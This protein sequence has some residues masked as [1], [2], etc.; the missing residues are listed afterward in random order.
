MSGRADH[1]MAS[2]HHQQGLWSGRWAQRKVPGHGRG[3][4]V[5]APHVSERRHELIQPSLL[6]QKF[7]LL[8]KVLSRDTREHMMLQ[9]K[10]EDETLGV[11]SLWG[12][13]KQV[14]LRGPHPGTGSGFGDGAWG[15]QAAN[16]GL[17][18]GCVLFSL[19]S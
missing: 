10:P 2:G 1:L 3:A 13:L 5:P 18:G 8:I 9:S 11:Q 7:S 14:P 15:P 4:W 12:P 19:N 6:L 17:P 16:H